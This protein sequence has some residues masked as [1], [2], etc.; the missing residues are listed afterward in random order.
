MAALE[1]VNH[2]ISL[3]HFFH[4]AF[5]TLHAN[6]EECRGLEGRVKSL[7]KALAEKSYRCSAETSKCLLRDLDNV[8][9]FVRQYEEKNFL[10]KLFF[11]FSGTV[12]A[13]T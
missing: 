10:L 2:L 13:G 9:A 6:L 7:R 1:F 8:S 5:N 3:L 12:I 4:E 11:C